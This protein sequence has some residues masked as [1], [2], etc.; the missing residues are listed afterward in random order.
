MNSWSLHNGDKLAEFVSEIETH[1]AEERSRQILNQGNS[2]QLI[3]QGEIDVLGLQRDDDGNQ[4]LF[5]IDIA[6][7]LAGLN[8]GKRDRTIARVIKKLVRSCASVQ[9][10]LPGIP[11]EVIFASPKVDQQTRELLT[12][13]IADI[14]KALVHRAMSVEVRLICNEEFGTEIVQK[15]IDCAPSVADT[16]EL[17]LRTI[18]LCQIAGV[19]PSQRRRVRP[20]ASQT[21]SAA[22]D[23]AEEELVPI[24]IHVQ[25]VFQKLIEMDRIPPEEI[26]RL[27]DQ[28]YSNSTFSQSYPVLKWHDPTLPR[29]ERQHRVNGHGRYY[30]NP[31]KIGDQLY[32]L[33]SQW[34]DRHRGA[35]DRWVNGR[36]GGA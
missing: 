22:Y 25:N 23:G 6:T 36:M 24:G 1:F 18:Q 19:D 2:S 15:V 14:N 7:H 8:L 12:D 21:G 32:Y 26:G 20:V 3:R 13:C 31:L 10:Y 35:F 4:R 33:C 30:S 5:A 16:S 11:A 34:I 29:H 28:R 17:F 27:I 9:G